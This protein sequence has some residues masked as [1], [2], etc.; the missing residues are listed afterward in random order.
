M[1]P[2]LP[3]LRPCVLVILLNAL[4]NGLAKLAAPATRP[5]DVLSEDLAAIDA[6]EPS[7]VVAATTKANEVAPMA[8]PIDVI[9][10]NSTLP[11]RT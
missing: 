5:P 3:S 8:R 6:G 4:T 2:S 11:L 9:A 10:S 1:R 7:N